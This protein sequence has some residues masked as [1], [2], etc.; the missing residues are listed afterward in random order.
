MYSKREQ[1]EV[2]EKI[3]CTEDETKRVDCPFCGGKKTLTVSKSDGTLIWNCYKASCSARGGK[4]V[5]YSKNAIK[6]KLS[7]NK[8]TAPVVRRIRNPLPDIKANPSHHDDV[9]EYL[10][11]NNCIQAYE[12]GAIQVTY[13]PARNRVLFWMNQNTGAVGRALTAGVKPK[14]LSYGDTSGVLSVGDNPNAIVVEDAASA[15]S[16]YTTNVY[17]GVALLGT[18]LSQEQKQQLRRYKT[19]TICLDKDA[20]SKALQLKARL[21]GFVKTSICFLDQDLKYLSGDQIMEKIN[22]SKRTSGDRL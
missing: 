16:V 3:R 12:D 2:L 5:G 11:D 6:E 14:W 19:V 4:R 10:D 22:E 13:D 21:S 9:M 20:S 15:C 7:S 8:K 17:T 18:N 1:Y